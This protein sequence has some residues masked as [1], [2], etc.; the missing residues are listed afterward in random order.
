MTGTTTGFCMFDAEHAQVKA[1]QRTY[2][3]DDQPVGQD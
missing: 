1:E 2:N 3:R